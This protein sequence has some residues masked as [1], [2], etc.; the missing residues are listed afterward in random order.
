MIL[1]HSRFRNVITMSNRPEKAGIMSDLFDRYE[2][3]QREAIH[4]V[5]KDFRENPTGR[6]MLVIPTAGGKTFTAARSVC[7]L[8]N[9]RILDPSKDQVF[10]VAHREELLQQAKHTFQR[11]KDESSMKSDSI[12]YSMNTVCQRIFASEQRIKLVVIDEAHHASASTYRCLFERNEVGVLGLT[13]TPSRTDGEP[14]P[15]ERESFSIGFPDLVDRGVVLKPDVISIDAGICDGLIDLDD[16]EILNNSGRNQLIIDAL[17]RDPDSYRKVIIFVGTQKHVV[18]LWKMIQKSPLVNHYDSVG[19]VTGS[20]NHLKIPRSELLQKER[21]HHR[22]I[23]IN[24]NVLTEG[25]DD[26]SINT[27]V[28]ASPTQSKLRYMQ[29]MGRAIRFDPDNLAKQ[30]FILEVADNLPN[31]RYRVD[32]RW[33]YA[34]ISDIL[35]PEVIDLPVQNTTDFRDKAYQILEDLNIEKPANIIPDA[36]PQERIHLLAFKY[37]NKGEFHH[38]PV[39]LTRENRLDVLRGINFII[40]RINRFKGWSA[41]NVFS[42]AKL[43]DHPLFSSIRVRSNIWDAICNCFSDDKDIHKHRFW[44][45]YITFQ[46]NSP[47]ISTDLMEFTENMINRDPIRIRISTGQ[48]SI[49]SHLLKLPLPLTGF[50]GVFVNEKEFSAIEDSINRLQAL[51]DSSI[52]EDHRQE[53]RA[54]LDNTV[55]PLESQLLV[56]LP[57]LVREQ[58]DYHRKL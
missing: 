49:L 9:Q 17:L 51:R 56:T 46:Y 8:F 35:E 37:Y 57:L 41:D 52:N 38:Y 22:S 3:F 47:Q 13:A 6:F 43:I 50:F 18:D 34:E 55:F 26:P 29:C 21:S 48:S 39:W 27:V 30:A 5:T 28:M 25:Y 58:L 12:V 42:A 32:N 45:K 40:Y 53:T 24:V 15:F 54:I 1:S 4:S 10:W 20:D 19:Y 44:V 31:I 33:L 11:L 2:E 7:A 23:M 16:Q 14:L 36:D